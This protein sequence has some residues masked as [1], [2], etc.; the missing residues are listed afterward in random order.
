MKRWSSVLGTAAIL[1]ILLSLRPAAAAD[2][3]IAVTPDIAAQIDTMARAQIHAG[4]TPGLAIGVVESGRIVYAR[5]FGFADAA[6]RVA[7]TPDTE[8]YAG[9]LTR[10]F[11]AAAMLLLVQD[12]KISLDDH[13]TK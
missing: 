4:R 12:G 2:T 10:Q 7:M 5:G 11:T 1:C 13:L 3:A 8:F 6:H 9:G